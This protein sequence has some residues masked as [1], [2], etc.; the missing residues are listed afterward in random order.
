MIQNVLIGVTAFC[1]ALYWTTKIDVGEK[2]A[3]RPESKS[4]TVSPSLLSASSRFS[5]VMSILSAN[6]APYGAMLLVDQGARTGC[7]CP[8][9]AGS[10]PWPSS[11]SA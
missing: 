6:V 1:V 10:L 7:P 11:P 4:G 2:R 8:C 5:I 3:R 9:A